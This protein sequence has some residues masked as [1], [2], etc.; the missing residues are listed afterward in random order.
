MSFENIIQDIGTN[1]LNSKA[2]MDQV[3]NVV[4][5]P[6]NAEGISGWIFDIP[7]GEAINLSADVTD[8]YTENNSYINDHIVI[9][10]IEVSL[11]GYI[12]ELVYRKPQ[13]L[14]AIISVIAQ[15]LTP[16]NAF[17]GEYTNGM[18]QAITQL[19]QQNLSLSAINQR[20]N[21]V[22]NVVAAFDGENIETIKQRNEYQKIKSLFVK[23]QLVTVQTPWEYL[24]NMVIKSITITQS[25]D[26]VSYSDISIS[27]K[28]LR[29]SDTE[30]TEFSEELFKSREVEQ[31][32][33]VE[34]SGINKGTDN[35]R[36]SAAFDIA[37]G[38]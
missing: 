17:L 25:D 3:V 9:K 18:S 19:I 13:G 20:I 28:Q 36:N 33:E 30:F 15:A 31:S 34:D 23:K 5:A 12:G 38:G 24:E 37:V 22:E 2:F 11:S 4:V 16:V 32:S 10:P 8:H 26:S 1:L 7:T 29:F 21:Q 6:Q 14:D 27:L 35:A